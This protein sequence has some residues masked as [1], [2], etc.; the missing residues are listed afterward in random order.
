MESIFL[1]KLY[2][3]MLATVG[4]ALAVI[5]FQALNRYEKEQ[6]Q[7]VY[8]INYMMDVAYRLLASTLIIKNHTIVPHIEATK[9]IL[10]GD[11]ELLETMLLTDEF[12]I[13][14]AQPMNYSHLP[15]E[16][17]VLVGYDDIELIQ[18]FDTFLYVSEADENRSHLLDFVKS[19]LKKFCEFKSKS[20]EEQEDILNTYCDIL[21]NLDHESSRVL[22][23]VRETLLPKLNKYIKEFQFILFRTSKVKEKANLIASLIENNP[24]S[25][26]DE[27]YMEKVRYGGIQSAL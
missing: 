5:G 6:K 7:K 3:P 24:D 10:E 25:F 15:N 23:F 12:D 4:A 16:Y 17:K 19:H 13:L 21:E 1:E 18:M 2:L 8:V 27:G 9:K 22:F 26:P 14:K 11:T 20:P